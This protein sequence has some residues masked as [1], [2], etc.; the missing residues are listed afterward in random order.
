MVFIG[1]TEKRGAS[2]VSLSLHKRIIFP[3][4]HYTYRN[5]EGY[6]VITS[7]H[8]VNAADAKTVGNERQQKGYKNS[9]NFAI[10][11]NSVF[12]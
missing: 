10:L 2:P 3:Y 4:G 5:R 12:I 11:I 1:E 6:V 8:P 7:S 9:I